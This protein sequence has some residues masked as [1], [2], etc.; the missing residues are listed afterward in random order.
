MGTYTHGNRNLGPYS[1]INKVT[2]GRG[3]LVDKWTRIFIH[4]AF[5]CNEPGFMP[6]TFLVKCT[7]GTSVSAAT[8]TYC[9]FHFTSSLHPSVKDKNILFEVLPIFQTVCSF[10]SNTFFSSRPLCL[11]F[12]S[13]VHSM[14][15]DNNTHVPI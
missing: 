4:S 2:E 6:P 5:V 9:S 11:F 14:T 7:Q 8:N 3:K 1:I 15:S 12:N 13:Q 10:N